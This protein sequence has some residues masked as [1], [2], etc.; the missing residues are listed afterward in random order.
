MYRIRMAFHAI[1]INTPT[2]IK[3]SKKCN[4]NSNNITI[5]NKLNEKSYDKGIYYKE[6]NIN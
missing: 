2:H 1:K 3:T 6:I 5:S 4:Y